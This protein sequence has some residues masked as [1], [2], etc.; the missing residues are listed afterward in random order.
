[1]VHV[2]VSDDF[3]CD[4][5]V[6]II[7]AIYQHFYSSSISFGEKKKKKLLHGLILLRGLGDVK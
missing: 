2:D 5:A 7:V 6:S 4:F 1:M 3:E